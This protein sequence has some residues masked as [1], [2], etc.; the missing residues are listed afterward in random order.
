MKKYIIA[1]PF[2]FSTIIECKRGGVVRAIQKYPPISVFLTQLPRVVNRYQKDISLP[3]FTTSTLIIETPMV[4]ERWRNTRNKRMMETERKAY[5]KYAEMKM[6]ITCFGLLSQRE[7]SIPHPKRHDRRAGVGSS[8]AGFEFDFRDL[9]EPVL[10]TVELPSLNN[11]T[12]HFIVKP[13][14]WNWKK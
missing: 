2:I 11:E 1:L 3:V 5:E 6:P 12:Y 14:P 4:S 13:L 10:C 8:E 9:T 7:I